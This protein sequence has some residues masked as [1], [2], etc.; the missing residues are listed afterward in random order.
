[1]NLFNIPVRNW[2]IFIIIAAAT[3][4]ISAIKIPDEPDQSLKIGL[5]IPDKQSRAAVQGAEMAISEANGKGGLNGRHF[6]LL[7]RSLEGPW[8]IGSKE[9]VNL[10][11]EENV[12][13]IMG[14]H[15]GRN[16]HLV[17]QVSAKTHIVFLSCWASDP[18]LSKAFVPW[19]FSCVPNDDQQ[20]AAL[21]DE[22]Y[23]KRKISRVGA[24]SD[25]GYDSKMALNSFVK[26]TKIS[27]KAD[28]VQFFYDNSANDFNYLLDNIHKAEVSCII[29]FGK[30]S[31][32][33]KIIDQLQRRKMNMMIFGT[34]SVLGEDGANSPGIKADKNIVL[35]S[36]GF[37]LR[38]EGLVF[39]N[40]YRKE[41][42][43]LPGEV[44][45]Y[46]YDGMNILIEAI[47]N[48]GSDRD[49]VQKTMAKTNYMGVTGSIRFDDKGNRLGSASLIEIQNG[50][51]PG[52]E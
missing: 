12:W 9:A 18:T 5:L 52:M 29:L 31:A 38:Q 36:S 11:F 35:V 10:V 16:A 7:V 45:A 23:V 3:S 39:R 8:G 40:K 51:P 32:S 33:M 26:K 13:A 44:A 50:I 47:K 46:A 4:Y 1:M 22:I 28:P 37:W 49:V 24:I 42:G 20:A 21:I 6:E 15:D 27:A 43:I 30:P 25:N 19:Y 34:L 48:C 2:L 14:S 17:E 41:Y